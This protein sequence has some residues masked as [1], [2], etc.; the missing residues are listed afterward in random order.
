MRAPPLKSVGGEV[1][2]HGSQP[3]TAIYAYAELRGGLKRSTGGRHV[4]LQLLRACRSIQGSGFWHAECIPISSWQPRQSDSRPSSSAIVVPPRKRTHHG[5]GAT[6]QWTP[7]CLVLARA[8]ARQGWERPACEICRPR[9]VREAQLSKARRAASRRESLRDGAADASSSRRTSRGA[10]PAEP[11]P[12]KLGQRAL[13]PARARFRS[14]V[15]FPT[16][17]EAWRGVL[18][19]RQLPLSTLSLLSTVTA[20]PA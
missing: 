1:S 10:R 18:A 17:D 15:A 2:R 19:R 12:A 20:P 8:I 7:P 5:R 4:E 6:T 16:G 3:R 11:A 9:A 13:S 14:R